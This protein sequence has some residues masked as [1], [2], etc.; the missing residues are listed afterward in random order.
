MGGV[1]PARDQDCQVQREVEILNLGN[2]TVR[3][4]KGINIRRLSSL[5][6]ALVINTFNI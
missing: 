6:F 1:D 5:E 4:G 2:M 3:N